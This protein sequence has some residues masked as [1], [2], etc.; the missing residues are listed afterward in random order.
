[1][2][3]APSIKAYPG[4]ILLNTNKYKQIPKNINKYKQI[5]I[6]KNTNKNIKEMS[7]ARGDLCGSKFTASKDHRI[8][9]STFP[10][11]AFAF[12]VRGRK[13]QH[14]LHLWSVTNIQ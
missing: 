3:S 14:K 12:L 2:K 5:S 10:T 4:D 9:L 13:I 8:S 1:M 7:P 11:T 6:P